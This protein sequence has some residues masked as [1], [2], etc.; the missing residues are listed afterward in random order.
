MAAGCFIWGAMATCFAFTR[1]LTHGMIFWAFNGVGL[2]LLL[3]NAQSLI[4]DYFSGRCLLAFPAEPSLA[5][6]L[7]TAALQTESDYCL[8]CRLGRSV[9]Q[10]EGLWRVLLVWRAWWHPGC[11]VCDQHGP[12]AALGHGG[13]AGRFRCRCAYH[14][15][16]QD[17][18]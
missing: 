14:R 13:M 16:V 6:P 17:P 18:T 15:G 4:A 7:G 5:W 8:T 2:G 3:P 9:E 12:H 1:T 11:P 10:R